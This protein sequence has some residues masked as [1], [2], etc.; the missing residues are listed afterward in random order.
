MHSPE[1]KT[2]NYIGRSEKNI[3]KYGFNEVFYLPGNAPYPGIAD[4]VVLV[5]SVDWISRAETYRQ[6]NYNGLVV[7]IA[8]CEDP[9]TLKDR[10]GDKAE[11]IGFFSVEGSI[12]I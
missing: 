7:D 9:N 12:S 1:S 2:I 3:E 6:N 4:I 5:P 11:I 8:I 10:M